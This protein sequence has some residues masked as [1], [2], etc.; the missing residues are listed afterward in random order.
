VEHWRKLEREKAL[1]AEEAKAWR[2]A[3]RFRAN[4]LGVSMTPAT[5][6]AQERRQRRQLDAFLV[7][8]IREIRTGPVA[9]VPERVH[10]SRA[11]RSRRTRA[12]RTSRGD[13]DPSEPEPP[14]GGLADKG[15]S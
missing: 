1:A 6:E 12:S 13:P 14:L 4:T 8:R 15:G 11:P 7:G 9:Q 10:S 5:F 2:Y 3:A